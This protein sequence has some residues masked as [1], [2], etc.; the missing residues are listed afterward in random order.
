MPWRR[1]YEFTRILV[2]SSE[3]KRVGWEKLLFQ[4]D[5]TAQRSTPYQNPEYIFASH[6]EKIQNELT[7][8]TTTHHTKPRLVTPRH[9]TRNKKTTQ[10]YITQSTA[11]HG[12]TQQ[13]T[14]L[15]I[16]PQL[17]TPEHHAGSQH[18]KTNLN[19]TKNDRIQ[20]NTIHQTH[21]HTKQNNKNT[22]R[23]RSV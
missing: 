9:I 8:S 1:L 20:L 11:R 17:T 12:T 18:T 6:S 14:T 3:L 13:A 10:Y 21:I 16:T 23:V 22:T 5:R 2:I 15:H 19:T 4:S 7:Q